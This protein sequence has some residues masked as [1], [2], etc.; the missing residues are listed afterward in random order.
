[1]SAYTLP[2]LPYS[3]DALEPFIDS[4][5]MEIHYTKHHQGYVDKLNMVLKD[6][7]EIQDKPIEELIREVNSISEA[8]R[9]AVRNNGG[10]HLNHSFFWKILQKNVKIKG[11]ILNAINKN[12][13][14]FENFKEQFKSTGLALFGSG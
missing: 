1:M 11:E 8:I 14:S 9:E 13:D 4:G 6:H 3:F 7:E 5:T 12:F 10:G 2:K